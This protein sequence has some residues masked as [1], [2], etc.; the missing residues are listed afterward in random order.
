MTRH[1]ASAELD[2][3]LGSGVFSSFR[4]NSG[5]TCHFPLFAS[6]SMLVVL[7]DDSMSFLLA[8]AVTSLSLSNVCMHK[9]PASTR[10][11]TTSQVVKVT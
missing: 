10:Q 2:P 3:F 8:F 6:K 4:Q 7:N 5:N 9:I 1:K 11:S